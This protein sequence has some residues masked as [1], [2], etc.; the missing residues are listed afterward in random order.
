MT[1]IDKVNF[2]PVFQDL[3]SQDFRPESDQLHR[4]HRLSRLAIECFNNGASVLF[5]DEQA[6]SYRYR[7]SWGAGSESVALSVKGDFTQIELTASAL[8][9]ALAVRR[10]GSS[11][12]QKY[13]FEDHRGGIH[14]GQLVLG[15]D[16]FRASA[17]IAEAVTDFYGQVSLE[18]AEHQ[19]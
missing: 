5:T 13:V 12:E 9:L 6:T 19:K 8:Q 3:L 16:L 14:E 10:H 4:T 17:S 11:G 7:P 18:A 1:K 2:H 15:E